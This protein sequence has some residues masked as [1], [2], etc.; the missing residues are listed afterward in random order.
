MEEECN[1]RLLTLFD[2]DRAILALPWVLVIRQKPGTP[3]ESTVTGSGLILVIFT[4]VLVALLPRLTS[5]SQLP[6]ES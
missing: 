3:S 6:F 5:N 1:Q 2:M 4:T